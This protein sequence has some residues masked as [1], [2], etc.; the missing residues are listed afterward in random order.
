MRLPT[1][2]LLALFPFAA[3]AQTAPQ[4]VSDCERIQNALAYNECLASFGPRVGERRPR[5]AAGGGEY[6][7]RATR[8]RGRGGRAMVRGRGGR[9]S[10]VFEIRRG[11]GETQKARPS[12]GKAARRRGR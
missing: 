6:Q 10:A 2:I 9:Q 3:F 11:R 4:S 8:R 5:I 7:G 1:A 12:R